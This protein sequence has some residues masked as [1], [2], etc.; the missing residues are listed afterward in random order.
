[1]HGLTKNAVKRLTGQPVVEETNGDAP[2]PHPRAHVSWGGAVN[3]CI[4][5]RKNAIEWFDSHNCSILNGTRFKVYYQADGGPDLFLDFVG[6]GGHKVLFRDRKGGEVSA[7]LL[8]LKFYERMPEKRCWML[9]E[10]NSH[11]IR[12]RCVWKEK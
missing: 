4:F 5:F 2:T 11:D 12:L 10:S 1:M 3:S 9:S 8:S 7:K 6:K